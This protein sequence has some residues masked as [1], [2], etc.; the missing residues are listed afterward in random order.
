MCIPQAALDK[1]IGN[2]RLSDIKAETSVAVLRDQLAI[3]DNDYR[4]WDDN[5]NPIVYSDEPK[6]R[7]CALLRTIMEDLIHVCWVRDNITN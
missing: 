7:W 4:L 3:T 6:V 1:I 5:E 2:D